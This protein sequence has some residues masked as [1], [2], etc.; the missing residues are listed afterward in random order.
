[1]K[2]VTIGSLVLDPPLILAPMAGITNRAFRVVCRRWGAPLCFTEMVSDNGLVRGGRKSKEMLPSPAEPRPVGV[3]LFGSDPEILAEAAR[4]AEPYAD[5]IDINMGCPVRKVV[6]AGAGSALLRD[7]LRVARIISCVRS[8]IRIPLTVKI[9]SGWGD[10]ERNFREIGMIAQ[11]EGCDAIT[12][13]P[14][15]RSQM[16]AGKAAWEEIAELVLLLS[17]PVIASGDILSPSD[18]LRVMQQTGCNGVMVARGALGAPWI[19]SQIRALDAGVELPPPRGDRRIETIV[20]QYRLL[21]EDVGEPVA[22]REMRKHASWYA[23]GYPNAA[24]FRNGVNRA[25]SGEELIGMVQS[26]FAEERDDSRG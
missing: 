4:R 3:Q 20:E 24:I 12:L 5:L 18:A 16:F 7:P 26:F 14:R 13:H 25:A 10:D 2:P 22:V 1:M 21:R 6:S 11:E 17:I 19:F 23:H 15:T 9:R 8:A